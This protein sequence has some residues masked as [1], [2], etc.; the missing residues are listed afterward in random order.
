MEQRCGISTARDLKEISSRF[1]HEG[2]AFLAISLASYGSDFERSLDRGY[3]AHDLF[4]GFRWR[5][6]LPELFRG[7]LEHVF[8]PKSGIL[9]STPCV[10]CIINLRQI[11]LMWAKVKS[12]PAPSREGKAIKQYMECESDVHN[13]DVWLTSE[14]GS[15]PGW[16]RS[17]ERMSNL[18]FREVF[19]VI[20]K[21]IYDLDFVPTHGSG[22]TADRLT[23]NSK[24]SSAVWSDKLAGFFDPEY[25]G[26][27][28]YSYGLQ[29]SLPE[30]DFPRYGGS[31]SQPRRSGVGPALDSECAQQDPGRNHPVRVV[32]VPKTL[33]T[34]RIIAMEPTA[35]MFVQQGIHAMFKEVF[36]MPTINGET[37]MAYHFVRYDSQI[38]NQEMARLGSLDGSLATLDLSSASDRV[39]N[40][41][42][43]SMLQRFP[44]LRDGVE[45]ARTDRADVPGI[46][47]IPLAKFASMGSA[48]C[49]PMEAMVFLTVVF[50]GIEKAMDTTMTRRL[51]KSMIGHV[52]VYGDDIIVP[53]DFVPSVI[54]QLEAFGFKVNSSKSFWT[55]KFRESCGKDYYD[56][57]D[58]S[59]VRLRRG[60]PT[61]RTETDEIVSF[62]EFRNHLYKHGYWLTVAELD[63]WIERI[64]PFPAMA[65]GA[66]G[67]GKYSFLGY[68][69]QGWDAALQRPL[70]KAAV[71]VHIKR[72]SP[73]DGW[74]AL[75]KCLTHMELSREPMDKDHLQY[76]GP[77]VRSIIKYR[78]V[79]PDYGVEVAAS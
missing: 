58:V 44:S 73:L 30:S 1:E 33:K 39:S 9:L 37:N 57:T 51:I 28:R 68:E 50:L 66:G 5:A 38:P 71:L 22:S 34:P 25:H 53:V 60:I 69:S 24:W 41:L 26:F 27:S 52:R 72:S 10:D 20:D 3:V 36:A 31:K 18:L 40:L 2:F 54:E 75:L 62:V 16:R 56:G 55:G 63:R 65:D 35:T 8:E 48:L 45:A 43:K 61:L 74:A 78:N 17:F 46:G 4:I 19:S 67:L 6:G 77:P 59:L 32:S 79:H 15:G 21:R 11:T 29:E 47:I 70:V 23:G 13:V 7:F 76:S 49:F 42:V 12:K 64:I 14:N